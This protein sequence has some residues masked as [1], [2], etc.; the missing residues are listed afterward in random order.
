MWGS[1]FLKEKK[2]PLRKKQALIFTNNL[3]RKKHF[4]PAPQVDEEMLLGIPIVFQTVYLSEWW[5]RRDSTNDSEM[6]SIW[7]VDGGVV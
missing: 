6:G 2:G 1:P 4:V 3:K 5:I 7:H